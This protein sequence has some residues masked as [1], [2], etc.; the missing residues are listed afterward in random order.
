MDVKKKMIENE[1]A[2]AMN[3]GVVEVGAE[4]RRFGAFPG[5]AERSNQHALK[6]YNT[7]KVNGHTIF[8]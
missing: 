6:E 3:T 1:I 4:S 2:N 5:S 7:P 8:R